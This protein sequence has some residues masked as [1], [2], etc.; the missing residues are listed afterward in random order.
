M[1]QKNSAAFFFLSAGELIK[2]NKAP[3]LTTEKD[4]QKKRKK[5]DVASPLPKTALL[6]YFHTNDFRI[7]RRA[8]LCYPSK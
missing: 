8:L 2:G 5:K 1:D 7:K 6:L 3:S 4:E